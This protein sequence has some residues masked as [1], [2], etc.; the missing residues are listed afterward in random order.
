MRS[1]PGILFGVGNALNPLKPFSNEHLHNPMKRIDFVKNSQVIVIKVGSSLLVKNFVL[2]IS[3]LEELAQNIHQLR[4]SGKKVILVTS[5]AMAC[6]MSRLGLNRKRG[7]IPFKQAM[8][9][10]GQGILMQNYCQVFSQIGIPVAQILLAPE[11]VHNRHKYLNARNTFQTLLDLNVLPI[12]NEND[13]VAIAELKFGDNDRLSALVAS[14][15][16]AQLLIILSDIEGL[17]TADPKKNSN[18]SLIKEVER[19]DESIEK[20][21]G[22]EGSSI[23]TGGMKSKIMASRMATFSGIGVILALGKDFSIIQRIFAGDEVGTFFYPQTKIL[24]NRKRWIAFGM[25]TRGR[26]IID[27]GANLALMRN[28]SLLPAGI[29]GVEGVF[30]AG[31][32]I[33]VVNEKGRAVAK[34]LVN[35][36]STELK[37]IRGLHTTELQEVFFNQEINVEVIHV[38]N[39]VLFNQEE[40]E[41]G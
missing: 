30:D 3:R 13:T 14:L 35:F 24:K 9:A 37:K 16:N 27:E 26:V 2:E 23:S 40:K 22:R 11:D 19:I 21:A 29:R 41:N 4:Q 25:M 28:K 12:V 8:A 32:C 31:D 7:D 10:V 34:G 5:G 15:I 20:M 36:S 17:F 18:A 33:E 1:G 38:D 39:L 6:G